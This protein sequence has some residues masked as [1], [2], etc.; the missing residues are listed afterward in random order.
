MPHFFF[1]QQND[2]FKEVKKDFDERAMAII[3]Q[4]KKLFDGATEIERQQLNHEMGFVRVRLNEARNKAYLDALVKTKVQKDLGLTQVDNH[5]YQK[6][7][8]NYNAP[9]MYPTGLQGLRDEF[10]ENFYAESIV[11]EKELSCVIRFTVGKDGTISEIETQ[12]DHHVFNIQSEI[13]LFLLSKNFIPGY[14]KGEPIPGHFLFP[15]K[16]KFK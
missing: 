9:P 2:I 12:G 7:S 8:K 13:A 5:R 3:L 14:Q 4:Y 16:M 10:A 11:G 6:K 1:A 15:I